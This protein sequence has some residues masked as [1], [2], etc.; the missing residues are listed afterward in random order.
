MVKIFT[1]SLYIL[2]VYTLVAAGH[3]FAQTITVGN[4][5]PGPYAPGS[6]ISAPINVTGTC[7][8]TTTSYNL[9]LSDAAG[10]FI[11]KKLIGTFSNF[12]ATFVNGIIP[13]GTPAGNGYKIEVISTNPAITSSVS[14]AFSINAG[15]GV[16]AG[17]N[18]SVINASYPEVFG[19]CD[20]VNNTSYSF[21]NQSTS[22]AAVTA[23]FFNDLSQASE[24]SITPTAA[25]VS[26]NARA[27]NYTITV[28]A[29]LN[30]I[31]GTESY[32]LINNVVNTSFGVTGTN[33]VCLAGGGSLTYNV[34]ISS[35][36]GIQNN[37]PGLIYN[38]KWG[39]GVTSALTLCD[40]VAS[41]GTI[42]HTYTTPSCG[43]NPNGQHNSFEVDLQPSSQYCGKVGTQVTSYA[44]VVTP[45]KNS[46]T[47]PAAGCNNTAVTFVNKSDPGQDPTNSTVGCK[48]ANALYT[49]QVDGVTAASNY[50]LN[51]NFVYT[52]TTTGTHTITLHL[53]NP[54]A[55]CTGGDVSETICIQNPPKP[56]F[57]LPVT[58]GCSPINI[59]PVNQSVIDANCNASNQ[60]EWTVTGP[61]AVGYANGTNS[62]SAQPQF[63]F[64]T[65]GIYQVTLGITTASCGTI[66][67]PAQTVIVDSAITINLSPNAEFC[68][69]NQTFTFGPAAGQTQT[70]ISGIAQPQ[71]N[72]YLWT[73]TGGAYSFAGGT[74]A[75]SQYPQITFTAFA[76]YTINVTAQN[77]CSTVTKS[78]M[79]SF[80][81]VPVLS[82]TPAA[83]AICPGS[84]AGL[85]GVITGNYST[86]Q[87][88]GAGTFSAPGSLQTN[89]QPT[90]AEINAGSATVTL[91]VKTALTGP[92]ADIQKSVTIKISP[93]NNITSVSSAQV[94]S[95]NM[96]GYGITSSVAGSTYSW[97]ASLT[98]GTASGFKNG[99]GSIINDLLTNNT[100]TPA[101]I[102]YIIT[103]QAN[104]C[105]GNPFTLAVTVNSQSTVTAV[106]AS[107]TVCNGSAAVITL[108]PN[109]A[110][111]LY[112]WTSAV[113]GTITGNSQQTTP[114]NAASINDILKNTGVTAATVKYTITP[115]YGTCPG[116][117]VTVALTVEPA[118]VVSNAGTNNEVC[119]VT[120]YA[121]NGNN[122]SPGTGQWTV[123]PAGTVTFNNPSVPNATANGMVPGNTY[124]FTWTI[125]APNN[126]S[127]NSSSVKIID[128]ANNI[129]PSFTASQTS[130]CGNL[131]VT[132][133]NTTPTSG[134][135]GFL[136]DF[137]DGSAQSTA[138]SPS[139]TFA[140][141]NNGKD[142]VY[143]VSLYFAN[144]CQPKP[145]F[146]LKIT[147]R[148]LIPTA[149]IL[150]KTTVGCSPFTL[151]VDNISPGNN[152]S[153]TYF[154]YHGSTLT[155]QI[156]KTDKSEVQFAPLAITKSTVYTLYMVA[157]GFCGNTGKSNTI[158]ILVSVSAAGIIANMY[159]ENYANTGCVPFATT[160]INNS[161][162]GDSYYYTI[163]DV[164]HNIVAQPLA[165]LQPLTYIFNTPGLYFITITA[166]TAC[167]KV[168]SP[169]VA[170]R[171]NSQPM[172][173]FTADVTSGC[174]TLTVNFNNETANDTTEQAT[175]LLYDWDFGDGSPHATTFTPPPHTYNFKNSPFTVTLTATNPVT[176]CKNVIAKKAYINV[177]A[178]PFTA[179]SETPDSIAR[180][181]NYTFSF[182]DEST[183]SPISWVWTFGDGKGSTSENPTHTYLDTGAYTVTLTTTNNQGCD[184]TATHIVQ[185]KGIPGQ[186]FLPTAFEPDGGTL[187]LKTFM[188]KGSGIR[189]WHLQI[190]NNYSQLVW[191]TSKLDD[192]G[193][194]V[195]GWDGTFNGAPMPQGVYVWQASATFINGTVWKG[196]VLNNSLPKRVGTIHLI[197]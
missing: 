175:S 115:H 146:T 195:E 83:T 62:S 7:V 37:F 170:V 125:S 157:T 147:V 38:I 57:T 143:T 75:N 78:Q 74:T 185:V 123:L 166:K 29:V 6:T 87:W 85:T 48:N 53:Q 43:N 152:Q 172:A 16:V 128:D 95:G 88:I 70:T 139:H 174:K 182:L 71:P 99:S 197:R 93:V 64:T 103:P 102:S 137:G 90:T 58:G 77:R 193:A 140:Q 39:D 10:S 119:N 162:G 122:P 113:T 76:N 118:P 84:P 107:N 5:D 3:V 168:E 135:T 127:T 134:T 186:L 156:T 52:F 4:V 155:Q 79:L 111:I 189:E 2:A 192:K 26:F 145:P 141:T 171:V 163:Y 68:G 160:F 159:L 153:Y 110:G 19:S 21:T 178:P 15:V 92:C 158:P 9:Y 179:F 164:N 66:T 56:Q 49:W 46:F 73:V 14:S 63:V 183:N 80:Q 169:S 13:A 81:N 69:S 112:T 86:Y 23:T 55:L 32:L 25:G 42:T 154:L 105:T 180:V 121:L 28:K 31:V 117:P 51:Q 27:A 82:V 187:E 167:A 91:D 61:G 35:P 94:C 34:D 126:C 30:G 114:I 150:P 148:P 67:T 149:N 100:G 97:T 196:N 33:T 44:Q 138:V 1:K 177:T 120:S 181:P 59:T 184:S 106:A 108:T 194:P 47:S 130:G 116:A 176:Y 17:V 89:Y 132:F 133:T 50:K 188:A 131:T 142:T 165:P 12:Y 65:V 40:I 104:G 151:V 22:G 136:W 54:N 98:S 20:G 8:P 144:A 11:A 24:G 161:V 45:P 191:E 36:S 18:S 190:F 96:L 41:G 129:L 124:I 101:V 72:T 173:Q 60:Y 109:F